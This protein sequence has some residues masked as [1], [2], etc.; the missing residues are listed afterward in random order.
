[1]I[2]ALLMSGVTADVSGTSTASQNHAAI[3]LPLLALLGTVL[4]IGAGLAAFVRKYLSK[5]NASVV[6][7]PGR[8]AESAG[9]AQS[10]AVFMDRRDGAGQRSEAVRFSPCQWLGVGR[11]IAFAR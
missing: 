3:V 10:H 6:S 11:R 5:R 2:A 1:M 4:L 9:T 8:R 7:R